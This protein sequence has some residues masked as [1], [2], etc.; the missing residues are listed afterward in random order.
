LVHYFREA[1]E[2]ERTTIC[3]KLMLQGH[4]DLSELIKKL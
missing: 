3:G 2:A 4:T 1:Q